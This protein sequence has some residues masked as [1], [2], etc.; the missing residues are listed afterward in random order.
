M[1]QYKQS[2]T[3]SADSRYSIELTVTENIPSDY[4]STNQ[5]NVT[6]TLTATKSSGYGY[7]DNSPRNNVSV[8]ING[9]NVY[10]QNITYDFRGSIP[11]TITLASGSVNGITHNNDGT[12]T[13]SVSG[14]FTD[15]TSEIGSATVSGNLA[16]TNIPRWAT[17]NS[18][19]NF[20]DEQNPSFT[21]SNPANTTMSCWIEPLPTGPHLAERNFSGTG[22]TYTWNLTE[23]ERIAIRK[24][25]IGNGDEYKCRIGLYSILGESKQASYKDVKITIINDEP[26]FNNFEYEDI[27]P[28]TVAL[29]GN[30]KYNIN[31]YSTIQATISTQ[32]KAIALKEAVITRY[33]LVI[34][35][36]TETA[37][38]SDN[39]DVVIEM[40]NAPTGTY[41]LYADDNRG[42][43]KA[44]EKFSLQSIE[45]EPLYI[46]KR[47]SYP[48]R[49]NNGKGANG[50]LRYKGTMWNGDFGEE[51]N[52]IVSATYQFKKTTSNEWIDGTTNI[53]PTLTENEFNFNNL[54]RSEFRRFI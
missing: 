12:K 51:V 30:N 17:M 15:P 18:A 24:R 50:Y 32:N 53:I 37:N 16:L 1:A 2:A 34:G 40:E 27:N 21:Y 45:Y 10:N 6:Y 23:Q 5:T 28:I 33:R 48:Y 46:D 25:C 41:T 13:I 9:S 4:I 8:W 38:Y 35:E 19:N 49:D 26:Q 29:T 3:L 11:K 36:K 43:S 42:H 14:S 22:G 20:N 44:V 39:E 47:S 52:E 7:Y 31:G 54:V